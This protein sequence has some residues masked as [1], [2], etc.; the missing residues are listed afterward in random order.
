M[1]KNLSTCSCVLDI[2]STQLQ[3]LLQFQIVQ[4]VLFSDDRPILCCIPTIC[5]TQ[6]LSGKR[7][8]T[9]VYGVRANSAPLQYQ[10]KGVR[11]FQGRGPMV[12]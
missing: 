3:V 10:G 4:F 9:R 1:V 8:F 11:T 5:P 12:M 2:S 7:N 6:S